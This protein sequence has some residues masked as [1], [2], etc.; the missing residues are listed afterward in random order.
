[1]PVYIAYMKS[2]M[3]NSILFSFYSVPY[4]QSFCYNWY[5]VLERQF[6]LNTVLPSDETEYMI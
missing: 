4:N 3:A 5:A 1:M 6:A 2:T